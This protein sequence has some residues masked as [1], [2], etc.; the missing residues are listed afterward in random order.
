MPLGGDHALP[1]RPAGPLWM[2]HGAL[3][4]PACV[5]PAPGAAARGW[6]GGEGHRWTGHEAGLREA[7]ERVGDRRPLGRNELSQQTVGERQRQPDP[8][9]LHPTPARRQMPQEQYQADLEPGLRGDRAE[10]VELERRRHARRV[11]MRTICGN[12]LTRSAKSPSTPRAWSDGARASRTCSRATGPPRDRRRKQVP[13]AD[14]SAEVRP[15]TGSRA[16]AGRRGST[17]RG[18]AARSQTRAPDRMLRPRPGAP[19]RS[20][21]AGPDARPDVEFL[22]ELSVGVEQVCVER[23]RLR[24]S[25]ASCGWRGHPNGPGWT[26][27]GVRPTQ[28]GLSG[29]SDLPKSI[30]AIPR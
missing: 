26:P 29:L 7:L 5:R 27:L 4:N 9:G 8:G 17:A 28:H 14:H 24:L 25:P 16:P 19:S 6:R 21:A 18:P 15:P 20:R 22:G 12:G 23:D 10:H 30:Q 1:D 11:R 3:V 2:R 13:R